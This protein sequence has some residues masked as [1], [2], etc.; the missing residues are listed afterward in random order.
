MLK[1]ITAIC[2]LSGALA[3]TTTAQQT[4]GM[5]LFEEKVNVHRNLPPEAEDMKA[6]IP[7]F[8]TSQSE[9]YFSASES[10]YRNAEE[11]D[12]M[13]GENQGMV[14][15][16]QRPESIHYRNFT[17]K[18][19]VDM[20]EFM[21]KTYLI[22]DSLSGRN[23]RI[24]GETKK[25][26]GYDCLRAVTS[27]TSRKQDIAAWF[28]DALPLPTGPA[29]F[30]QLPGTILEVDINSGE[31]VLLAKKVEF[32]KLKKGDLEAPKK[33]EKVTDAAFKKIVD[34][35]LKDM[36]GRPVRIMRN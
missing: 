35:R 34:D 20:R 15:K 9:L 16:F 12:E 4:E 2:L 5:I 17:S 24:T 23:W 26:L 22:E 36:G 27:D 11:E 28:T 33:G 8:R 30:D 25:I 10:L 31:L 13:E 14:L 19:K 1:R 29:A 21:G 7:E 3:T 18:R 32:K 6:M